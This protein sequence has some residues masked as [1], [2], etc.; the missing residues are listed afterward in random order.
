MPLGEGIG[1]RLVYDA[2]PPAWRLRGAITW[3]LWPAL[4]FTVI[5]IAL[6]FLGLAFTKRLEVRPEAPQV[7]TMVVL[8][9][10]ISIGLYV[11][12]IAALIRRPEP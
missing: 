5:D 7:L 2:V 9:G 6:C 3:W 12:L 4:I 10:L 11:P 8:L 1:D